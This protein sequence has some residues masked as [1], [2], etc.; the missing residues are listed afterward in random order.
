[1]IVSQ[2]RVNQNIHNLGSVLLRAAD[3]GD[4][5]VT[6]DAAR[7]H[8]F[9][10]SRLRELKLKLPHAFLHVGNDVLAGMGGAAA[11]IVS[12]QKIWVEHQI[13]HQLVLAF[14]VVLARMPDGVSAMAQMVKNAAHDQARVRNDE[15]FF[16]LVRILNSFTREAIKKHDNAPVCTVIYSYRTLIRRLLGDRPD[17]IPP[18]LRYMRFYA[19]FAR[20]QGLPFTYGRISYE[21]CELAEYAYDHLMPL[22]PDLLATV[23]AFD[24]AEQNV[25]LVKSRAILAGY[26]IEH[27]LN[28]EYNRVLDSL[29][30]VPP[31][32]VEQAKGDMLYSIERVFWEVND[33]GV[34]FDYVDP[35][36]RWRVIQVFDRLNAVVME[37]S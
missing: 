29:R 13:A 32:I 20:R 15:V 31:E 25:G 5:D 4:R 36:R 21:L 8:I 33:H 11:I 26:F 17:L 1:V 27:G 23:L 34:N 12:E 24:G 22:A 30:K 28:D 3:R 7:T 2:Q 10:I 16:L 6:L 14:K 19:D 9:E 35:K 18:L 37:S